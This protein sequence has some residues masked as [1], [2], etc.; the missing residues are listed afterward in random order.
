MQQHEKSNNN[1]VSL[2]RNE[3][4]DNGFYQYFA[5]VQQNK[6]SRLLNDTDR[7]IK[8]DTITYRQLNSWEKEGLLTVQREG[9]EWRRFSIIDA[10]WVKIVKE[11]RDFGMSRE[12]LR[13]VKSCLEF[14]SAR[15]GVSMPMLEFYTA[16]VIGAKMP[17][18][19]LIFKDGV[20]VPCSYTQFKVA[21]ER[22]G[23]DNHIQLNLNDLLQEMFPDVDLKPSMKLDAPLSVNELELLAYLGLGKFETITVKFNNGKME[24]FEGVQRIKAKRRIQEIMQEHKYQNIMIQEEDGNITAIFQ[25]IKKK[26]SKGSNPT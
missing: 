2:Y 10:L 25:T 22:V 5:D 7:N 13:N 3:A 8:F 1:V 17:V 14:E 16:F 21:K 15:C 6:I 24:Q 12:Q 9:R 20:A 11:L 18:L 4:F 26:F 19:I 23:M